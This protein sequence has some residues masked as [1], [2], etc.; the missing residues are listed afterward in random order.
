MA[1]VAERVKELVE[2]VVDAQGLELVDVEH[3]GGLL[4]VTLDRD[5]GIDLDAITSA[6]QHISEL[7]DVH[8]PVPG[9][10]TLEVTSPGLE[11]PLQTP[12]QFQ[13]FVG[14]VVNVKTRSHVEGDRRI[15]AV[16]D[17]ADDA[18]ITL[19]GRHLTYADIERARTVFEWGPT[20]KPGKKPGKKPGSK[21][22]TPNKKATS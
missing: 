14:T 9:R 20:E 5:G 18:G 8:D 10:Y 6:T 16:L 21:K 2:P 15:E 22:A 11:R 13:R 1:E 3:G 7:L 12:A 19:A 17:H 4:R